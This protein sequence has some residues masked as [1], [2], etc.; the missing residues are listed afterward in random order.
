MVYEANKDYQ[1]DYAFNYFGK[2]ITYREFFHKVDT[3]SRSLTKLGVKSDDI[4]TIMGLASPETFYVA[5]ACSK[6]GAI[7]NLISV[8]AG[9]QE[10]V[11]YL[12]EAKS[13]VFIA[14]DLF[15]DKIIKALPQTGVKTVV[16]MSL[17]ESMP[18]HIKAAFKL[19]AKVQKCA[20]FMSWKD[21]LALAEGQPKV[22]T[23]Q[24]KPNRFSYLAH[25]VEQ[26]ASTKG[27]C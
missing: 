7:I 9:E 10:L 21:F 19:K 17:A 22:R 15:N 20:G 4:V 23:F 6:I 27:L 24:F 2:R 12:N 18:L 11:R 13:S 26:Q 25:T 16:N 3:V 1:S 5:Y 8:L 14:L